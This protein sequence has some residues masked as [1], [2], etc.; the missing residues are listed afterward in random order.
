MKTAFQSAVLLSG[1]ALSQKDESLFKGTFTGI[2]RALQD[3]GDILAGYGLRGSYELIKRGNAAEDIELVMSTVIQTPSVKNLHLYQSYIQFVVDPTATGATQF[4]T[5]VC[6]IENINNQ[7]SE[8]DYTTMRL[9][10]FTGE[11]TFGD[12]KTGR[13]TAVSD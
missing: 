4:E 1:F 8:V 5:I 9:E 2:E 10:M 7:Q 12:I 6:G 3:S 11:K 13:Y